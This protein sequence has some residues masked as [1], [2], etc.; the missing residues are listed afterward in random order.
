[1]LSIA[2]P[3][4]EA[5][6]NGVVTCGLTGMRPGDR[7]FGALLTPQGRIDIEFLAERSPD[8]FLLDCPR[9]LLDRLAD[10]LQRLRLR[11]NVTIAEETGLCVAVFDGAPDPRS[12]AAPARRFA[13]ISESL[14]EGG[15]A[16]E[17][18]RVAAALPEQGQDYGPGEVYP[19]DVNMDLLGGIDFRKGCFI[20]QEVVS[21]MK[22]RGGAR[23]RT[24][25]LETGPDSIQACAPVMAGATLLG[26]TTSTGRG[27]AL[28]RIRIDRLK[29]ALA[30]GEKVTAGEQTVRPLLPAWLEGEWDA[31]AGSPAP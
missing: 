2:G 29:E 9:P 12:P 23:R 25:L 15:A 10:R 30:A 24:L 5:F 27:I 1:V 14:S 22:R 3:D 17:A 19:A 18:A 13:L 28:A 20:G 4:A 21:R 16:Y 26:E 11:A 8:G 7:R 31:L 6:L